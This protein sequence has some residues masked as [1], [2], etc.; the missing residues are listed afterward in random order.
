M[1]QDTT[2]LLIDISVN[3]DD[4]IKA[5]GEQTNA[6]AA[7][8]EETAKLKKEQKEAREEGKADTEAYKLRGE[9]IAANE[10]KLKTLSTALNNNQKVQ[11][12][13]TT[14][15][16]DA[17][18]AYQLLQNQYSVA[19]QRA[20]DLTVAY[21]A[22]SAA[23]KQATATAK[24]MS[25]KLKDVD[26]SVG[27]NQRN[28]GNYTEVLGM[29]PGKFGQLAGGI[30]KANASM[31]KLAM[32]PIGAIIAAVGVVVIALVSAFKQNGAA[33]EKMNQVMAPLKTLFSGFMTVLGKV[34]ETLI[35]GVLAVTKFVGAIGSF[36][37]GQDKA[38]SATQKAIDLEKERQL[39]AE[40]ER[41]DIV[42]DAKLR[43][44]V[45][46]LKKTLG[47]KDKFTAEQR[48]ANARE[49]DRLEKA[50]MLDDVNRQIRRHNNLLAQYK[51]EG[52]AYKDLTVEQKDAVRKSEADIYNMRAEYFE[53]TRRS[54][55]M[56][57][58]TAAEIEA[59]KKAIQEK[60]ISDREKRRDAEIKKM[61]INLQIS[62]AKQKEI[63][64]ESALATWEAEKAIIDKKVKYGKLTTEEA[65]LARLQAE[66]RYNEQITANANAAL[67]KEKTRLND[68]LTWEQEYYDT[69]IE[70]STAASNRIVEQRKQA[71]QIIA[72][73]KQAIAEMSGMGLFA[74]Q[75]EQLTAQM[76]AELANTQL[77]E[78]EKNLIRERYRQED[79]ALEAQ[80]TQAKLQLASGFINSLSGIFDEGTIAA[81]GI[82]SA[83]IAI[84]GIAGAFSAYKSMI[85]SGIPAPYN[86]IA[87]GVAAA[88]VIA[89]SVKSI[90]Q[91]WKVKKSTKSVASGINS[92]VG[93]SVSTS[94]TSVAGSLATRSVAQNPTTQVEKGV[95]AAL[96]KTT[97]QPVLVISDVT[98]EL[99]NKV[100]LKQDNAL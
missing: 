87:G 96:S 2:Q 5:A 32:N 19:A 42:D 71:D 86:F 68:I 70:L 13:L 23:A 20:K 58:K 95:S 9:A 65:I 26:N 63:T 64:N 37:T 31:L 92:S 76:N 54:A 78:Q 77:T 81:K 83:Q 6:I 80:K 62:L 57:A 36:I 56:E 43:E 40:Q 4:A 8:R 30:D 75:Q 38:N 88:G 48:L 17:T 79:L 25:D 49:I 67:E 16:K 27:Q 72:D 47:Q 28:V 89:S 11:K 73:N 10:A 61:E 33:V 82:A 66:N 7:L 97:Q 84:D 50:N 59:E 24:S 69:E 41:A 44:R 35:D 99:N 22:N 55:S 52:K 46:E 85:G 51:A 14:E 18:G 45:G 94:P 74:Y 21:G 29:L 100:K 39:I 91:V 60:A 98:R 90:N 15:T 34:V 53:K 1:A 3:A 93:T 12:L